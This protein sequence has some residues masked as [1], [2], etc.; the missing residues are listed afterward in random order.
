MTGA[1]FGSHA[2]LHT[3]LEVTC[4]FP[5]RT[6]LP[7]FAFGAC[8]VFVTQLSHVQHVAVPSGPLLTTPPAASFV[9]HQVRTCVD[10]SHGLW[11]LPVC[12][13]SIFLNYQTYHHLLPGISH[14]HFLTL[15]PH[16]DE[17]LAAHG[18][19]LQVASFGGVVRGYF[20]Y[21]WSLSS[22][23]A[24]EES[25]RWAAVH[26]PTPEAAPRGAAARAP[27]PEGETRGV[28]PTPST[29]AVVS[30]ASESRRVAAEPTVRR[31]VAAA[32]PKV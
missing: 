9:R 25:T 8:F 7:L 17:A 26:A 4:C 22:A 20:A 28:S 18:I 31:R 11:S 13:L 15:K 12:A 27:E 1:L 30:D 24:T 19:Q 3:A 21:M 23:A 32:K 5:L 2:Y 6:M 29:G 10:Y 14:F 16:L